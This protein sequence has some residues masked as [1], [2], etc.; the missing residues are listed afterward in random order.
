MYDDIFGYLVGSSYGYGGYGPDR[1]SWREKSDAAMRREADAT[2][3]FDAFLERSKQATSFPVTEEVVPPSVHLTEACWKTFKQHVL[4]TGCTCKR[5]EA[6]VQERIASKET[7][8]G[9]LYVI[10]CTV[11]AH[12]NQ[13]KDVARQKKEKAT[14]AAQAKKEKAAAAE[15]KK[16]IERERKLKAE[17]ELAALVKEEYEGVVAYMKKDDTTKKRALKDS[18]VVKNETDADEASSPAKK[19]KLTAPTNAIVEYAEKMHRS[20]LEEISRQVCQEKAAEREKLLAELGKR[21]AAR[22]EELKKEA[23]QDCDEILIVIEEMA[24]EA[25]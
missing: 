15:E 7:R 19:M 14:A 25:N 21:M 1:S 4:A 13:A 2:R 5:R 8:K 24:N 6:T 11:P 9:K 16:R 10:S 23:R 20:R 3:R 17:R 22:E 18:N 12:P